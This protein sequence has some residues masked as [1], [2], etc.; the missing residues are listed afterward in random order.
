M[1]CNIIMHFKVEEKEQSQQLKKVHLSAGANVCFLNITSSGFLL[2]FFFF[3]FLILGA[4]LV[5]LY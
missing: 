4:M 5:L 2:D 1:I 3:V